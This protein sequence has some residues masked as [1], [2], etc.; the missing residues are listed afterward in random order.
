MRLQAERYSVMHITIPANRSAQSRSC[1]LRFSA[2]E[3]S[4][5][6]I[7]IP[8]SE[9]APVDCLTR[10]IVMRRCFWPSGVVYVTVS[11]EE[12]Q[13]FLEHFL[14]SRLNALFLREESSVSAKDCPTSDSSDR[15]KICVAAELT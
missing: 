2:S 1:C 5:T 3:I 8:Y 13:F 15:S 7:S 12:G 4:S 9:S 6:S 10:L 11:L 14:N